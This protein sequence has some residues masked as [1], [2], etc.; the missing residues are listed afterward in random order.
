MKE[1]TQPGLLIE[2]LNNSD[3]GLGVAAYVPIH[4]D[5]HQCQLKR[6]EVGAS[7]PL[8]CHGTMYASF[9][10]SGA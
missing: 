10:L 6:V 7:K 8:G 2:R 3:I 5:S 4:P 1:W 9:E